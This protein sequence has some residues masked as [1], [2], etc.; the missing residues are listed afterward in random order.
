METPGGCVHLR[1]GGPGTRWGC[2]RR[3]GWPVGAPMQ[4]HGRAWQS[5]HWRV[6]WVW[7]CSSYLIKTRIMSG[8]PSYMQKVFLTTGFLK[9]MF[10]KERYW[11]WSEPAEAE[12]SRYFSYTDENGYPLQYPCLENSMDRG[13]W[14]AIV[15]R[16]AK[17]WTRLSI[18]TKELDMTEHKYLLFI[19]FQTR[20]ETP[21]LVSAAPINSAFS[22][23]AIRPD[24][25]VRWPH[26]RHLSNFTRQQ[27][28]AAQEAG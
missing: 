28:Q 19:H 7:N 11:Y 20:T 24:P 22:P 15:Q 23:W 3:W 17:S 10:M 16:I 12:L 25:W 14:Q 18:S 13:V 9:I 2:S 8:N 4:T 21:T 27:G 5:P 26:F 6:A 1:G